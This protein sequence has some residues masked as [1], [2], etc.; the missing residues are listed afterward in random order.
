MQ[1]TGLSSYV[2]TIAA[3]RVSCREMSRSENF[4]SD[5]WWEKGTYSE[6]KMVGRAV[7]VRR[8]NS[9]PA[10][11]CSQD[12]CT[13]VHAVRAQ[14]SL[15]QRLRLMGS[16]QRLT[17]YTLPSSVQPASLQRTMRPSWSIPMLPW[18]TLRI[19]LIFL[20]WMARGVETW[21]GVMRLVW[22]LR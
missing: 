18:S 8:M 20:P 15:Q 6:S 5:G 1:C 9:P 14:K 12:C 2:A 11:M 7:A 10:S 22:L 19:P 21:S 4:S 17:Q 13:R 16:R 3:S